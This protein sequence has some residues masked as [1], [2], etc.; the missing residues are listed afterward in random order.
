MW[1]VVTG[2]QICTSLDHRKKIK[3]DPSQL[4]TQQLAEHL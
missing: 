2:I 3:A 4:I 1:R